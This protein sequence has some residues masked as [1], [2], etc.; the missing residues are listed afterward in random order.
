M[1]VARAEQIPSGLRFSPGRTR[2]GQA[3]THKCPAKTARQN[4]TVLQ[5]FSAGQ[6]SQGALINFDPKVKCWFLALR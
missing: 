4:T 3:I 6:N 1:A 5:A 2:V